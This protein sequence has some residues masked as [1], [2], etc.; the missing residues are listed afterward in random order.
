MA[1]AAAAGRVAAEGAA[2]A[3]GAAA[4]SQP[5]ASPRATSPVARRW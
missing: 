5:V 4:G 1:A 2:G 3:A